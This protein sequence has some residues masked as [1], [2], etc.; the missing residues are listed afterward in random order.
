[1][2][3]KI[4]IIIIYILFIIEFQIIILKSNIPSL[5]FIDKCYKG[6]LTDKNTSFSYQH[7]KISAIIPVYNAEK[8]IHYSLRSIQNQKMKDIEIIIVDDKSNDKT[9]EINIIF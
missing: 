6:I 5:L 8:Y 3:L 7:P 9:I 1:M 4:K 2:H